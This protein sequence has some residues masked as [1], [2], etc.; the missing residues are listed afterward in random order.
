MAVQTKKSDFEVTKK[1]LV[2]IAKSKGIRG[3]DILQGVKYSDGNKATVTDSHRALIIQYDKET[4]EDSLTNIKTLESME[5]DRYPD[6]DRMLPQDTAV[7]NVVTLEPSKI[8]EMWTTLREFKSLKIKQSVIRFEEDAEAT[9]CYLESKQDNPDD[10]KTDTNLYLGSMEKEK[11]Y[12][13]TVDTEYLLNIAQF[14]KET[15]A[16]AVFK[17]GSSIMPFVCENT[18]E[19]KFSYQYVLCPVRVY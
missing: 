14:V 17:F 10:I 3:R 15:K 7:P 16:E 19:D 1:H 6:V 18:I 8:K 5:I 12:K 4:F 2:K 13:I 11:G 9:H